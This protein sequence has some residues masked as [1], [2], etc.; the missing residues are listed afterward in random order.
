VPFDPTPLAANR[1]VDLPWAPRVGDRNSQQASAGA[2][3][4][5]TSRSAGPSARLDPDNQFVPLNLPKADPTAWVKPTVL[6]GGGVLLA[7]LLAA[8]PGALRALQRRR[9]LADG[10][11]GALWDELAATAVDLGL[12]PA[13]SAT[14]RQTARRLAAAMTART[15][16]AAASP[17]ARGLRGGVHR[18]GHRPD[19]SN[20]SA[21][22][23]VRRLALAE[24]AA[25]YGPA[26][27][28]PSGGLAPALRAARRGLS[29]AVPGRARWRARLWPE[30]LVTGAGMRFAAA[31][32][33]RLAGLTRRKARPA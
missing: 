28:A 18:I 12:P 19:D 21:V 30:S 17:A 10:S 7:L 25:S 23:A 5:T 20:R 24:E 1:Q 3:A 27:A 33:N 13:P 11:A 22:D 6:I 31:A 4:A 32:R 8:L 29:S 9:R 26:G 15:E 2:T 16:G 14:P